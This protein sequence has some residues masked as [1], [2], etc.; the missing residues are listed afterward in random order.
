M[1]ARMSMDDLGL[2]L[3]FSR[4]PVRTPSVCLFSGFL[5]AVLHTSGGSRQAVRDVP[6]QEAGLCPKKARPRAVPSLPSW[7]HLKP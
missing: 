4:P 6:R 3:P 7:N 5:N 2:A 1:E